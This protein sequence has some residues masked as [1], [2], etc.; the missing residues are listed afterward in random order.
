MIELLQFFLFHWGIMII[1][2]KYNLSQKIAKLAVWTRIKL[3]HE[4]SECQFCM[5][6]H[7]GALIVGGWY[8]FDLY[9]AQYFIGYETKYLLYPIMSAALINLV[10]TK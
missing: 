5:N 6:H 9:L 4:L 7:V 3:L 1:F 8:L 10:V 2:Y